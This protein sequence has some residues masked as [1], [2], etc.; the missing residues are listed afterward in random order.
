M[1]AKLQ[2]GSASLRNRVFALE[3]QLM[4]RRRRVRILANEEISARLTS[5]GM[6]LAAVG[7]GV[8]VE[9]AGHQRAWSLAGILEASHACLDLMLTFASLGRRRGK[10][11]RGPGS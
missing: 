5:P 1:G 11:E 6:M 10:R 8:A 2:F 3:A 7:V 9:Q 4:L